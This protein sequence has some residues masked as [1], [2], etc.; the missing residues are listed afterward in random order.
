MRLRK[1]S[2]CARMTPR[3]STT[4]PAGSMLVAGSL[5]NTVHPEVV[6][7]RVV[8]VT[9]T[10]LSAVSQAA[11]PAGRRR[12]P[13]AWRAWKGLVLHPP[14]RRAVGDTAGWAACATLHTTASG[15]TVEN[16]PIRQRPLGPRRSR[17]VSAEFRPGLQTPRA[18]GCPTQ[19]MARGR[20]SPVVHP[21]ASSCLSANVAAC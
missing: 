6:G 15:C 13:G 5:E 4:D 14:G 16:R 10:A 9:Q 1:S 11:Q 17:R 20:G 18:P 8:V 21:F 3:L 19:A 7:G 12:K 2:C